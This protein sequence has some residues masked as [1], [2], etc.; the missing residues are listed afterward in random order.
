MKLYYAPGACSL[1]G[2]ISLH[3]A[4]LDAEFERVDIKT[5]FTEHGYDYNAINPRGY[6]PMLVLDDGN[7]VTENTAVL[8]WIAD[9]A[10]KLGAG[11][12]LGRTRL[13][14]MLSW[15]STELHIA[16]KPFW[17]DA[18]DAEKAA[19]GEAVSQRLD[20]LADNIRE[21][22]LFGPHFT[23]ADA[24]LFAM[25]RWAKAF[26]VRIPIELLAWFERVAERETVRRALAEEGLS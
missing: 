16:F 14:E 1:A 13:I 12:P 23:V 18:S 11:G 2:R 22:Y 15:L 17:H 21:F 3:E 6:V 5:K 26:E 7:G 20:L 10:P 9:V 8:A 24:Y 4:G 19:A 25:L